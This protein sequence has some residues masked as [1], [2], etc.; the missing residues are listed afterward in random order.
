MS[1]PAHLGEKWGEAHG[2]AETYLRLVR[3]G[4]GPGERSLLASA[5]A[6]A[7]EQ[8]RL[9]A[10]VHPVTLVMEALFG[11]LPSASA[12]EMTPPIERSRML[13]E[14]LEFPIHNWLRRVL[15]LV[16]TR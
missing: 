4:F 7:R 10:R 8:L 2:R 1:H 3:G 12:A 9:D 15:A 14:P 6:S 16:G 13:P 5:L 11:C